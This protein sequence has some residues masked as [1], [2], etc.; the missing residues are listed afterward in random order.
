M[1]MMIDGAAGRAYDVILLRR[2]GKIFFDSPTAF[3]YLAAKENAIV[4]VEEQIR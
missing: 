3:H 2:G 4:L 1:S